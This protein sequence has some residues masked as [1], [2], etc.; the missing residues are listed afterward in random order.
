MAHGEKALKDTLLIHARVAFQPTHEKQPSLAELQH[1]ASRNGFRF[2]RFNDIK[3]HSY[4]P[5]DISIKERQATEQ[6]SADVLFLPS[7]ECMDALSKE[8]KLKLA[9]VLST[10]FEANDIVYDLVNGLNQ[11]QA[12]KYL[13][14][15]GI[16]NP[17]S[18]ISPPAGPTDSPKRTY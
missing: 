6:E 4:L 18:Q 2:Y 9:F 10:V 1:W 8:Q 5:S 14:A 17:K 7:Q 13:V 16:I 3:H 11:D 15:Q 12:L